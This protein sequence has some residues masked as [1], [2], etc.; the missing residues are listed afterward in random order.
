MSNA[1]DIFSVV[2]EKVSRAEILNLLQYAIE[3]YI[4]GEVLPEGTSLTL[5]DITDDVCNAYTK[6]MV[7]MYEEG[8]SDDTMSGNHYDVMADGLRIIFGNRVIS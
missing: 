6:G 3:N 7:R 2:I 4:D 1:N 8:G 5:E